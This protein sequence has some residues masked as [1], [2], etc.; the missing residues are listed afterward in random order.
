MGLHSPLLCRCVVVCRTKF[1]QALNESGVL[2]EI[3]GFEN[4]TVFAP[5]NKAWEAALSSGRL[6][7]NS[8]S[9]STQADT[10]RYSEYGEQSSEALRTLIR[11]HVVNGSFYPTDMEDGCQLPLK[12]DSSSNLSVSSSGETMTINGSKIIKKGILLRNG[13]SLSAAST[14]RP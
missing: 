1:L 9:N 14:H 10:E 5:S 11:M 8:T 3:E 13:P 12:F 2:D 7:A 6:G 4:I